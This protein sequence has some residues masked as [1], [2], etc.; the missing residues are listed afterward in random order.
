MHCFLFQVFY[1]VEVFGIRK[2]SLGRGSQTKQQIALVSYLH[3]ELEPHF[4]C[5]GILKFLGLQ[6]SFSVWWGVMFGCSPAWRLPEPRWDKGMM[7]IP[8][9]IPLRSTG[10]LQVLAAILQGLV[11]IVSHLCLRSKKKI[12]IWWIE[13]KIIEFSMIFKFILKSIKNQD[14]LFYFAIFSFPLQGQRILW[15]LEWKDSGLLCCVDFFSLCCV[16]RRD[17]F[18]LSLCCY[19]RA[20]FLSQKAFTFS[21]FPV[22]FSFNFLYVFPLFFSPSY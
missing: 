18:T 5:A 12:L 3:I 16:V 21:F 4:W 13:F 14:T 10:L 1:D 8:L 2:I 15:E 6:S 7:M 22:P 17:L 19:C 11:H 9:S 20:V